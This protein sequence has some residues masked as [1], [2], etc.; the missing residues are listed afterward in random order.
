MGIKLAEQ[1]QVKLSEVIQ[2]LNERFGTAFTQAD[3]LAIDSVAEELKADQAVQD[4]ASANP[5][6][7]FALALKGKI[8]GAFVDRMEKNEDIAA[9]FLN[10]ADFRGVLTDYI[11]KK[12][13]ADLAASQS[14]KAQE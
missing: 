4:H 2:V 14:S 11:V 12:V 6:D 13:H 1:E 10:D 5:L 3:Q 8:E 9:R 7:N